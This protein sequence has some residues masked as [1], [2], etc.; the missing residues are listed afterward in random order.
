MSDRRRCARRGGAGARA[1]RTIKRV[2]HV[3]GAK[4]AGPNATRPRCVPAAQRQQDTSDR[5][6][7]DTQPASLHNVE[8]AIYMPIINGAS[9]ERG[10]RRSRRLP[11]IQSRFRG[12]PIPI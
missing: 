1:G 12:S 9:R 5:A 8:Q 4:P 7:P 11:A 2:Q 3:P 10:R 6:F